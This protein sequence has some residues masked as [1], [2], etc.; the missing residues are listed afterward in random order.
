LLL[1]FFTDWL[2]LGLIESGLRSVP[3]PRSVPSADLRLLDAPSDAEESR[4]LAAERKRSHGQLANEILAQGKTGSEFG[5]T[6]SIAA[7]ATLLRAMAR[8]LV[9][10]QISGPSSP[11]KSLISASFL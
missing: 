8:L 3:D 6:A 9:R 5:Q 4:R 2:A 11:A 10:S 7:H 1:A